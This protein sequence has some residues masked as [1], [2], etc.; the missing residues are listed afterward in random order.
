MVKESVH[1]HNRAVF[2]A[3]N[4]ELQAFRP[5]FTS[6][7]EPFPWSINLGTWSVT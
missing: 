5:F 7:G 2:D 3:V 4:A 6:E 1:I